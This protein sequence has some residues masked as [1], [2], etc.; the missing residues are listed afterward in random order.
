MKCRNTIAGV[1]L[2]AAFLLGAMDTRAQDIHFTQFN[3]SPLTLNPAFTGAFQGE[4][5]A[6]AIYRDQ[7]RSALG[8]AAFKTYAASIDAP[9]IRDI[10]VDDYLAGG[11]Q[12][13]NDRAG[14]GNLN[15]FSI[16]GSV[17]YH[18]FFGND[19]NKSLSVGLQGGYSNKNLDLSKLYFSGDY[20]DGGWNQGMDGAWDNLNNN[21]DS[22]IVNVGL[23][24]SHKVS[25]RFAYTL[26]GGMNNLTQP[27]ESFQKR[28]AT[29][30][31]GL[32]IRSTG[33]LG[34]VIGATERFSIRPAVLV[35]SQAS[36]FELIGG[37]E[38]HY[39]L[40]DDFDIPTSPAVFA[41]AWY[42]MDDAIMATVGVEYKG[43][44]IGVGYDYTTSNFKASNNNNGGFEI[45]LRYI[46]PSPIDFA[47]RVLYPCNR[48]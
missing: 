6:S 4:Y 12:L 33:Q 45:M 20:T 43:F 48:F 37:S 8:D 7:W 2:F 24:W 47:R 22:W 36:A 23:A 10:G 1:S 18:K 32:A 39:R 38:F 30:E 34:A 3:A 17:A 46:A 15:N 27:F 31:V 19:G 41:G 9:L 25:D 35:Q 44:R 21:V 16:L 29:S 42:R 40:G 26:G 11:I 13:Y 28:Q 14:D 5:R